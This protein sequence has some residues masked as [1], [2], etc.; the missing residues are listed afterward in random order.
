V[1]E[2]I[3]YD[4]L[5]QANL[6]RV[7]SEPDARK[8]SA[9]IAELYAPDAV[10]YEPDNIATGHAEIAQAVDALA[11]SLPPEF[12]FRADGPAIGHHGLGRL[13]WLGG[14]AGGSVAVT[15]TDVVRI[16]AG[17]IKTIHVFLDPPEG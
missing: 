8:R 2:D 5:M 10:L 6:S 11:K 13:R 1:S 16:E 12:V 7:F 4:G 3:D 15:G 9:A 14:P 17:L